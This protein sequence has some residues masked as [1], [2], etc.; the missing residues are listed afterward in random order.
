[1]TSP[2]DDTTRDAGER[3]TAARVDAQLDALQN[4]WEAVRQNVAELSHAGAEA[5]RAVEPD[6]RRLLSEMRDVLDR[7]GDR[8]KEA[9]A[10][11]GAAP[12]PPAGALPRTT[13]DARPADPRPGTADEADRG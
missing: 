12:K 1:M 13:T 11:T 7:A 4:R 6:V 5:W 3:P 8:F 2:K 10:G 9:R